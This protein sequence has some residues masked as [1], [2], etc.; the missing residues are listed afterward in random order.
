VS[1]I[2]R[3][4]ATDPPV[5]LAF[6]GQGTQYPGMTAR[7]YREDP[8]YR[9][10]LDRVSQALE[11]HV[12]L[13]VAQLIL[14]DDLRVYRA[15]YTQPALFAVEYALARTVIEGGVRPAAVV[16][17]SIGEFAA[18]VIAGG[19]ELADAARLIAVRGRLMQQLRAGGGMLAVRASADVLREVLEWEPSVVVAAV[20]GPQATVLSGWLGALHRVRSA[21]TDRG[22]TA[23][24]LEVSHAFHSPLMEPMLVEFCAAADRLPYPAPPRLPFYST[25]RGRLLYGEP[26]EAQYWTEQIVKPVLFHAAVSDLLQIEQPGAVLEIGPKPVLGSMIRKIAA[27]AGSAASPAPTVLATCRGTDASAAELADVLA[28]LG[29]GAGA[30]EGAVARAAEPGTRPLRQDPV[31]IGG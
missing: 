24:Q 20:N 21:L 26:L 5:V 12:G 8:V 15:A 28:R 27:S 1:E 30:G 22:V 14:R 31:G 2:F 16:G 13:S 7:L 29:A 17:H 18:A 25:L 4:G 3:T 6:A 10:H 11:P 19:L 23:T 9:A